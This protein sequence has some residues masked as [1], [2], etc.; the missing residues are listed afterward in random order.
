VAD[1]SEHGNKP[2]VAIPQ[3]GWFVASQGTGL[4]PGQFVWDLW[5]MEW[6]WDRFFCSPLIFPHHYHSTNAQY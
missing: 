2:F 3:V 4:S 5:W 1:S 6:H